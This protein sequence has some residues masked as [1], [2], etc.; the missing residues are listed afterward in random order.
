MS[1]AKLIINDKASYML[2]ASPP[3]SGGASLPPLCFLCK[4]IIAEY[5][6]FSRHLVCKPLVSKKQNP[7]NHKITEVFIS[8][9]DRI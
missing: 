8:V 3:F 5:V 1:V 7:C 6:N 4:L 9:R 2:M